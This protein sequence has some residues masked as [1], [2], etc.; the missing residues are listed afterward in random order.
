M[1]LCSDL[2]T[3][4]CV[5]VWEREREKEGGRDLHSSL[6]YEAKEK[7]KIYFRMANF[8]WELLLKNTGS[9][10]MTHFQNHYFELTCDHGNGLK[11]YS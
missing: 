8:V 7:E 2:S 1:C 5:C 10:R 9:T 11:S 6:K 3:G 4:L